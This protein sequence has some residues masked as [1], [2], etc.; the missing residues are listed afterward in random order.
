MAQTITSVT[1]G[2][3]SDNDAANDNQ[4]DIMTTTAFQWT[5][6]ESM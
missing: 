2:C 6:A 4:V 1:R 3:L 5:Y